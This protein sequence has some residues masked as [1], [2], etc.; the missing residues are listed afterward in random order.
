MTGPVSAIHARSWLFVPGDRP[1]RFRKAATSGADVVLIDL[2]DAVD[3]QW[4]ALARDACRKHLDAGQ[5]AAIRVNGVDTPYVNEDLRALAGTKPTAIVVPKA[6]SPEQIRSLVAAFP[7]DVP[8]VALIET[9]KGVDAMADIA[10]EPAVVRL[11]LGHIDLSMDLGV[12]LEAPLLVH[13]RNLMVLA[14]R[15]AHLHPPIDGICLEMVATDAVTVQVHGAR[16]QGFRGKLCIH[17]TQVPVV[18]Y[19]FTPSQDDVDWAH[20]VVALSRSAGSGAIA[21][22]SR[23]IDR[24]VI[25][26]AEGILLLAAQYGRR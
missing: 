14:S 20:Q 26:R 16:E 10:A 18:N 9:I 25:K 21:H 7:Q 19:G 12:G 4:K 2:E 1:D 5:P 13:V 22:E 15:R 23:M 24:A 3:P 8:V 17:P 6:E 11:A